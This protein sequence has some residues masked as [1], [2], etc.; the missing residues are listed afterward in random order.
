MQLGRNAKSTET[1]DDLAMKL[2]ET[3]SNLYDDT[4]TDAYCDLTETMNKSEQEASQYLLNVLN[5]SIIIIIFNLYHIVIRIVQASS[6]YR[7]AMFV[8]LSFF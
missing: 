4:W 1:A 3:F 2:A 8:F 5:V 6:V 7:L